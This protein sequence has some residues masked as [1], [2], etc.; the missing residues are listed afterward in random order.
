[1]ISRSTKIIYA[2]LNFSGAA[3]AMPIV[4]YVLPYFAT[5]LGM[6]LTTVG[7]IFIF[8][9]VLD[10]FT[11]PLMGSL[12]DRYPSRWGK[13]KH[14][15]ALS[16]P[17]LM[18]STVLLYLPVNSNPSGWYFFI[19]LFLLYSGFTLSGITQLSWSVFLAPSY[20]DKTNLLTLRE[21]VNVFFSLLVLAIPAFVE[22]YFNSP[23][24]TKIL[25]IGIFVLVLLPVI[26]ST[27]L[28]RVPDSH[29]VSVEVLNPF[30]VFKT[31][32]YNKNL[33]IV[34]SAGVLVVLA[35][36]AQGATALF[37]IDY[38]LNLPEY[39][40]RMILLYFFSSICGLQ[41]WRKLALK[42]SKHE[43]AFIC[44]M[45]VMLMSLGAYFVWEFYLLD[46]P[47]YILLGSC[48]A[49][50]LI[51]IAY[52][53]INPLIV[54]MVADLAKQDKELNG[55]DRSASM[56][57]FYTTFLK[58]GN[59]FAASI[60]YLIL[61]L[62]SVFDPT[63]GLNNTQVSL[64][65]LWNLYIFIPIGCYFIAAILIKQFKYNR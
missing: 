52:A 19:S 50:V 8:G 59:A 35:Q 47:K 16:V 45:Y 9:R 3:A 6:G 14:W 18:I 11:D 41:I 56:Y 48:I 25:A 23:I 64:D 22:L 27:A 7:F 5:N 37:V 38:I 30:K 17:I 62:F 2:L 61:G 51:G 21:A 43:A 28:F 36:G 34:V 1:M 42:K 26:Y 24:E 12:I 33:K 57:S 10:I 58:F 54:A 32:F 65:L 49:Y 4:V 13:H 53:G 20:D 40:A 55:H 46:N 39:S 29:E 15:I 63:L 44:A 60:P 31:F